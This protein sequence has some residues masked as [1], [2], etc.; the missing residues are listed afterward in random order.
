[1]A[2][3]LNVGAPI[4]AF[5]SHEHFSPLVNVES[6]FLF[7]FRDEVIVLS[8]TPGSTP[9]NVGICAYPHS[10]CFYLQVMMASSGVIPF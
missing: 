3:I 5:A 2:V 8:I 4:V 1:M 6:I 7:V 10:S 9:V